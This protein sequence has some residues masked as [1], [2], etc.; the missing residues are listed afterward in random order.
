MVLL[1]APFLCLLH[2]N[3]WVLTDVLMLLKTK[4][5]HL[6][7]V[8]ADELAPYWWR[9]SRRAFLCLLRINFWVQ[10]LFSRGLDNRL[11]KSYNTTPAE[12]GM[13]YCSLLRPH[14]LTM[15]L[16]WAW[17][18]VFAIFANA[19]H[20]QRLVCFFVTFYAVLRY[21]RRW[22]GSVF[23]PQNDDHISFSRTRIWPHSWP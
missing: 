20:M 22:F 6:H 14:S 16:L 18:H 3:F 12:E 10:I 4:C 2:I 5:D 23:T 8:Y 21:R 1:R 13:S 19:D 9:W 11:K 7:H 15:Y 17:P